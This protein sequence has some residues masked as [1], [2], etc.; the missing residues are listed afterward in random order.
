[1]RKLRRIIVS[2]VSVLAFIPHAYAQTSTPLPQPTPQAPPFIQTVTQNILN[3]LYWLALAAI[4]GMV[5][6]SGITIITSEDPRDQAEARARLIR[7]IIGGVIIIGGLQILRWI[8][9]I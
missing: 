9:G 3:L 8:L 7:V 6:W 1:M 5:I 2:V 4:V